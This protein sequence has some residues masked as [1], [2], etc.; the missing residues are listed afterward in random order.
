MKKNLL[1]AM[2]ACATFVSCSEDV[3]EQV[4]VLPGENDLME[5]QFNGVNVEAAVEQSRAL[6]PDGGWPGTEEISLIGL[7]KE[8]DADWT[9][10]ESVLFKDAENGCIVAAVSKGS[11]TLKDAKGEKEETYYY[12]FDSKK[13]FS[14]Y[15]CYPKASVTKTRN[16]VTVNYTDVTGSTDILAGSA[17]SKYAD[18]YNAKYYRQ[19]L[20]EGDKIED[21]H[22][23]LTL[24]H[25]LTKLDFYVKK[26]DEDTEELKVKNI[27]IESVPTNLVLTLADK[28][29][30][31]STLTTASNPSIKDITVFKST[32]NDDLLI[33]PFPGQGEEQKGKLAGAVAVYPSDYYKISMELVDPKNESHE[34]NAITLY[35]N[36]KLP[37]AAGTCY[38]VVLTIYGMRQVT[39]SNVSVKDWVPGGSIEEEV[40]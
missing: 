30:S 14:F 28:N 35:T 20:K 38:Q 8:S 17:V 19:H 6:V 21:L 33:P 40:N 25:K 37:F 32:G 29:N 16:K 36:D 18:G 10:S 27:T 15:A 4:N 5:V 7:A 11:V 34:G 24:E 31:A 26:G 1:F 13:S 12:P 39:I 3:K 2:V 9:D 23:T 22:P